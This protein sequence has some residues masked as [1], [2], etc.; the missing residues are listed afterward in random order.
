MAELTIDPT[1]I[2]EALR[3]NVESY[4]PSVEREEVGRVVE[5][6]DGIARVAGLPR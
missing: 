5:A 6:G 1:E 3:K 2:A 4:R